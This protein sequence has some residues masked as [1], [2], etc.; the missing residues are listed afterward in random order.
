M[1]KKKTLNQEELEKVNGGVGGGNDFDSSFSHLISLE[2]LPSVSNG[3]EILV[4]HKSGTQYIG[5]LVSA[6]QM[7]PSNS[8]SWA[9]ELN[10][11]RATLDATSY[12]GQKVGAN[13][14]SV[15]VYRKP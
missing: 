1:D 3:T 12:I 4:S 2:E 15:N 13:F 9:I 11:T 6:F 14:V 10:V 8:R 7:I 5:K